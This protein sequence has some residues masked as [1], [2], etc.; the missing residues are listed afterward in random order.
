MSDVPSFPAPDP[1]TRREPVASLSATPPTPSPRRRL[2][3]RW[4]ALLLL[5]LTLSAAG[6]LFS[7]G[8]RR[9]TDSAEGMV[10]ISAGCRVPITLRHTGTY[11]V[12]VEE[13]PV[14]MPDD[15]DCSNAGRTM[16]NPHGFPVFGFALATPD[17]VERAVREVRPNRRYDLGKRSGLLTSR[18][19]GRAGETLIVGVV[20]DSADVAI[21]IGDNVLQKRTPWRVASGV[22]LAIGLFLV[23]LS[24]RVGARR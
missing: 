13:G 15:A 14:P 19:E 20:A 17:G 12:Y 22:V 5:V 2:G 1:S 4:L 10:R 18:F 23:A 16:S 11:H 6:A 7:E 8:T 21:A 3:R 24:F 9:A